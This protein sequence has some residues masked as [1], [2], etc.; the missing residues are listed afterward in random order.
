[1]KNKFYISGETGKGET[2]SYLPI[3]CHQVENM[4]NK[5]LKYKLF[6]NE[7]NFLKKK[8]KILEKHHIKGQWAIHK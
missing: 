6:Y 4:K 1:M 3:N 5:F 8:L 2:P 7:M